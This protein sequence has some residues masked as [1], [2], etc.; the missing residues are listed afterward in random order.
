MLLLKEGSDE[1]EVF[2]LTAWF[3]ASFSKPLWICSVLLP[4]WLRFFCDEAGEETREY[5]PV[6]RW[7]ILVGHSPAKVF[8]RRTLSAGR[9]VTQSAD[10]MSTIFHCTPALWM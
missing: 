8:G 2:S 10:V 1:S 7:N 5:K 3:A 6:R 4:S 9:E